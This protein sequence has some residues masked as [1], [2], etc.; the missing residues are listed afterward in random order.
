MQPRHRASRC[1]HQDGNRGDDNSQQVLQRV[2]VVVIAAAGKL[3]RG[4]HHNAH[5]RPEK[6][7]IDGGDALQQQSEQVGGVLLISLAP[8]PGTKRKH[9][10]CHQQQPWYQAAK[11]GIGEEIRINAP[12]SEPT[13][14]MNDS[15]AALFQ[16]AAISRR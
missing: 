12:T 9:Q 3:Q 5:A 16:W 6:S 14:E 8:Q 7:A 13:A 15:S 4:Q 11:G 2:Q 10:R 1:K